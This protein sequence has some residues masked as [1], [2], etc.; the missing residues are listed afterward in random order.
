M[1]LNWPKSLYGVTAV[2]DHL[3][4]EAVE[5]P[6]I[7]EKESGCSFH[8]DCS[9]RW[10]EVH[11]FGDR[12]YNSHDSVMSGG[13]WE[14][15]YEVDAECVP[16]FVRNGERLELANR[17]MLPRFCLEAEIASTHILADVPRHLGPPVVPGH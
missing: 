15:D 10:N 6:D 1:S 11:P 14:F 16:L 12:V 5:F 9:M 4:W 2:G 13:L 3:F 8:C 7:V 17:R